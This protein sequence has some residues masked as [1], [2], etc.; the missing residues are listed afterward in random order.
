MDTEFAID[1]LYAAGWW[2]GDADTCQRGPDGRWFPDEAATRTAFAA[3]GWKVRYEPGR[4]SCAVR[5]VWRAPDGSHGAAIAADAVA[6]RIMAY[7]ALI[8]LRKTPQPQ[9]VDP[10]G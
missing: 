2:P 9:P 7:T 6:A 4:C 3:H 5:A 8:R 1:E 10:A